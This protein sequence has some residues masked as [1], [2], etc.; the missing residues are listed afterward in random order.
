MTNGQ[1]DACHGHALEIEIDGRKAVSHH[2]HATMEYPYT[3]G[4]F[5][6]TPVLSAPRA[7]GGV[8]GRAPGPPGWGVASR[9]RDP[10]PASLANMPAWLALPRPWAIS[11]PGAPARRWR[12]TTA[13]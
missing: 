6:G 9:S 2:C 10:A 8:Q 13:T 7:L 4:C 12:S 3:I 1:L 5:R 11:S